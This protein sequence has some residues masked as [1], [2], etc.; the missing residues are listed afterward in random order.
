MTVKQLEAEDTSASKLLKVSAAT[1][2]SVAVVGQWI[3]VF[4]LI[5]SYGTA[6]SGGLSGL[7]RA[8]EG[9]YVEGDPIGNIAFIVHILISIIII[10]GGALQLIPAVRDR[11]PTFHRWNGR[12]F[13]STA[14]ATSIGGLYLVWVRGTVGDISQHLGITGDAILIILFAVISYRT[15]VAGN[16]VS[17]RRWALRL[18][19]VANAVWFFRIGLMGW[20]ILNQGVVGFDEK[21]F[22]G[23]FLTFLS[24]A[25]YLIP[26]AF[27]EFY[28]FAKERGGSIA[29]FC[30]ALLLLFATLVTAFGTF[31]ATIGMWLPKI[32]GN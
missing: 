20:I 12:I 26:L 23:P 11:F 5:V 28:F 31:A 27:L 7:N 17:H 16:F 4:Y 19:L 30:C 24:F 9:A 10:G 15:A 6:A 1:W 2:F 25:D 29:K 22:T 14:I 13:I 3:F 8:H 32:T 18:F 21:T